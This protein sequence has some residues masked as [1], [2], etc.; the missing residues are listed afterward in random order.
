MKMSYFCLGGAALPL[1]RSVIFGAQMGD[2]IV[3]VAII[4]AYVASRYFESQEE[5]PVNDKIKQDL[6]D[7]RATV[8]ALKIGKTFGR[9]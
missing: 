1:V 7:M 5:E 2:A 4:A 3:M 8:N 9:Q 6:D